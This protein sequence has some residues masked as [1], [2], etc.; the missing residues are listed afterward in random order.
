MK[1][2][3]AVHEFLRQTGKSGPERLLLMGMLD[4]AG[5]IETD[6]LSKGVVRDFLVEEIARLI[7]RGKQESIPILLAVIKEF[8]VWQRNIVWKPLRSFGLGGFFLYR[9]R[10]TSSVGRDREAV[11][12]F[13]HKSFRAHAT[14]RR[15]LVQMSERRHPTLHGR[16]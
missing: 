13:T 9:H 14:C 3:F 7:R 12:V 5:D 2:G 8:L 1:L 16:G 15:R 4:F 11:V 6:M 10:V